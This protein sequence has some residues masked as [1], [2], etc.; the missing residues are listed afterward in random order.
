MNYAPAA[1]KHSNSPPSEDAGEEDEDEEENGEADEDA[2]EDEDSDV[3]F[4]A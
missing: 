3:V 2:D 1:S 4:V